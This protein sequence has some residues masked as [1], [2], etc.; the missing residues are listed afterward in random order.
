MGGAVDSPR[1]GDGAGPAVGCAGGVTA[2]SLAAIAGIVLAYIALQTLRPGFVPP[3]IAF[4]AGGLVCG[5]EGLGWISLTP[6][7]E[8]LKLLAEATLAFVLFSDAARI[9]L[10]TLR[11]GYA[12][13]ARLLGIGLPL[14]IAAGTLAAAVVLPGLA[15]AECLVV[16]TVLAAT[17]AAL[18]QAVVTDPRLPAE[19][20][21]GLNVE[22]GLNDGLCVP[23]LV[24]ALAL[25]DPQAGPLGGSA[26]A[27]VVAE[28]IGYGVLMGAVA[29]LAAA[30][31]R[32]AGLRTAAAA[33]WRRLLSPVAAALAYGLAAPLGG[34]GFIAAF[35]AGAV[36]GVAGG[37]GRATPV[38][39]PADDLGT[40][41][42]AVT[43][44][45]FGAAFVGPLVARATWQDAAY[46]LLSLTV[47]RM[48]PVA[49]AMLGTRAG[50]ATVAFVG[51]SG[52]RGLA[53]IVFAV[54]VVEAQ[55]PGTRTI[56]DATALTVLAS[57]VLHGFSAGPLTE[58]YVR[59]L[60]RGA[61]DRPGA[62]PAPRPGSAG[63]PRLPRG[64]P[65]PGAP[66][67]ARP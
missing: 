50:P 4:V 40:L 29:G 19:I 15:T 43:F 18:G 39:R 14:T 65:P 58:R 27:R 17:D 61:D 23:V 53:S 12:L 38:A 3:A 1:P 54:L 66:G 45:V 35:V 7:A 21:Q 13:P 49:L 6:D 32:R 26:A 60:S 20:R 67:A 34:S 24:I 41:L 37:P 46:A 59:R 2:W 16:A 8:A 10:R 51:W 22:S 63:R 44:I 64:R 55:V 42:N 48:A 52:P 56:V 33:H 28:S 11:A 62:R 25:A 30:A 31:A 5:T 9:D 36:F 57:V 47:V